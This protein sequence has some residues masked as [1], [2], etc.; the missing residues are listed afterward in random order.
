M[1][2]NRIVSFLTL[3][4]KGLIALSVLVLALILILLGGKEKDGRV[5]E[6]YEQKDE[7]LNYLYELETKLCALIEKMDGVSGVSVVVH[8]ECGKEK[9][10]AENGSEGE[11][12]STKQYAVVGNETVL[13][14]ELMPRI[15]GVAVVCKGTL[16]VKGEA[17]I[18]RLLS[19]LLGI[20]TNH[21][22][23]G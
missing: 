1:E 7:T 8:A 3:R 5:I 18:I 14:K 4:K 15:T 9:V 22:Y 20:S 16:T 12:G 23:V 11:G 2:T 21:I 19:S 17:E 13:I 6:Q 10:Y